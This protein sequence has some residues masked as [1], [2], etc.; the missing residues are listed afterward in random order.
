MLPF[1]NTSSRFMVGSCHPFLSRNFFSLQICSSSCSIV[2]DF[3]SMNFWDFHSTECLLTESLVIHPWV[4]PPPP[5]PDLMAKAT[6]TSLTSSSWLSKQS[7]PLPRTEHHGRLFLLSTM[8]WFFKWMTIKI[9]FWG[10]FV[11]WMLLAFE[12]YCGC[13]WCHLTFKEWC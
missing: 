7:T 8:A 2:N 12:P 5:C 6:V 10:S 1:F 11:L 4:P 3:C 13:K 9:F